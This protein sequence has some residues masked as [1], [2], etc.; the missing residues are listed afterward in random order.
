M[1]GEKT[2][3]GAAKAGSASLLCAA[4]L[5]L[6]LAA[7]QATEARMSAGVVRTLASED[8]SYG[9]CMAQF[10]GVYCGGDRPGLPRPLGGVQLLRRAC[11]QGGGDAP[12]RRGAVG[13]RVGPPGDGAVGRR[14]ASTAA[15]ASR[16]ASTCWRSEADASVPAEVPPAFQF[17]P[18][19]PSHP[20]LRE[21]RSW[22]G[23]NSAPKVRP[24]NPGWPANGRSC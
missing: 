22:T 10:V 23:M 21:R 5:G 4:L 11:L 20:M 3:A 16:R 12:L 17:S 8:G 2:I 7:A 1:K 9:G 19:H 13:V 15:T 14:P 6:P 18:S 24:L